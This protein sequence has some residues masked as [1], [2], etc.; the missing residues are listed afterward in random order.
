MCEAKA[1]AT[2][3]VTDLSGLEGDCPRDRL[4]RA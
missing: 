4:V 2:V 3:H 1:K